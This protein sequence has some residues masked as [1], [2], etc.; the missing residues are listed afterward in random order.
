MKKLF[1]SAVGMLLG[2]FAFS[3]HAVIS[4]TAVETGITDAQTAILAIIGALLALSTAIFGMV[5]VYRFVSRRA[6]A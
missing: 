6:G 1:A 3:A 4:T 2:M 5:K